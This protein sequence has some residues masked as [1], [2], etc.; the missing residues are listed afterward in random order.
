[1]DKDE[2]LKNIVQGKTTVNMIGSAGVASS[3]NP[4]GVAAAVQTSL[5]AKNFSRRAKELLSQGNFDEAAIYLTQSLVLEDSVGNLQGVASDLGNL[6]SICLEKKMHKKAAEGFEK[7]L[8]LDERVLDEMKERQRRDGGNVGL[9]VV[10]QCRFMRGIH[11]EGLARS[12][13]A[14]GQLA[15]ATRSAEQ[16]LAA[17]EEV[18]E[19][20]FVT[21][22]KT[23]LQWLGSRAASPHG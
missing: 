23:L 14:D 19:R 10:R 9:E 7:A 15:D 2:F 4:R 20:E 11:L 8:E 6:A 12:A 13:I 1:M 22:I 3:A 16:A 17:F 18:G 21:Q 5:Q